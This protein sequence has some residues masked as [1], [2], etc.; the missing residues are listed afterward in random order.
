MHRFL[1]NWA[2]GL[3]IP[4]FTLSSFESQAIG[5]KY[6]IN[7][8]PGQAWQQP[9]YDFNFGNHIDTHIQLKLVEEGGQPVSLK[10][11]FYVIETG[12][13]YHDPQTGLDLLVYHHPRGADHDEV[14]GTSNIVCKVGWHLNAV[15]GAAKFLYHS[16]I[17]SDDHPVWMVNRAEEYDPSSPPP[18]APGMVIPQ[19][20]YYSHFHWITTDSD[21]PR[22]GSV[23]SECDKADAGQLQDQVPTAV[24]EVCQGWFLQLDAVFAFALE[25]G[26]ELIPVYPGEDLRSHLNL[27]TNYDQTPVVN[28]T[29]TR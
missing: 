29:P 17:N 22:A 5:P 18:S 13:V 26:N 14:C 19:P 27:V 9:P 8:A 7:V 3:A 12:D 28:I 6:P 2:I 10:G 23:Q 11:S 16:G 20:G 4:A 1:Y 25:H 24:N 15:P 21:D